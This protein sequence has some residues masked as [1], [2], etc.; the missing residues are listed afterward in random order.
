MF[1]QKNEVIIYSLPLE[2]VK[3]NFKIKSE[4]V[5]KVDNYS[6]RDIYIIKYVKYPFL[7]RK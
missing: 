2:T 1:H 7:I 5:I 6:N 3:K 4:I